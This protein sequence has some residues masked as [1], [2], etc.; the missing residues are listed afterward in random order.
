MGSQPQDVQHICAS[1]YSFA[2][3][4]GNG[5]VVTW[6]DED[7]GGDC[8]FAWQQGLLRW[9]LLEFYKAYMGVSENRGP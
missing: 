1:W 4:L 5:D 2:A 9:D 8:R 3:L 7:H 6:G